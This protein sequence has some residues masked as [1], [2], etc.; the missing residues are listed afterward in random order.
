MTIR[1]K[2]PDLLASVL[3]G[4]SVEVDAVRVHED[5]VYTRKKAEDG[6]PIFERV[7]SM[8]YTFKDYGNHPSLLPFDGSVERLEA[9]LT[10]FGV[11]LDIVDWRDADKASSAGDEEAA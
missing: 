7:L 3:A 8:L 4:Y 11:A 9:A 6:T 1:E 2:L 5:F 10:T